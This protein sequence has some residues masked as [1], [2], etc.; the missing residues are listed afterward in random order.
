MN[1]DPYLT[2]YSEIKWRWIPD[3]NVKATTKN[4]EAS[5]GECVF[6]LRVGEDY[7]AHSHNCKR[8][9]DVLDFIKIRNF[10][11]SKDIIKK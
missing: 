11:S 9:S 10:R 2:P 4:L 6:D 7:L 1:L 8:K 3:L 5:I